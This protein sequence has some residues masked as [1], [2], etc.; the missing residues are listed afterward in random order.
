MSRERPGD[1]A[2][3]APSG[4]LAVPVIVLLVN[5]ANLVGVAT[6]TLLLIGVAGD[7]GSGDGRAAVLWTALGYTV[8][9]L[10]VGTLVGMR[11][12]RVTNAWLMADR[13]PTTAEAAKALRLPVDT[14][15]VA[16][17]IW[18]VAAVLI[19]VVSAAVFPD[20]RI[21]IRTGVATLLGGVVTAGVTYL[22]VARAARAVTA[23]AL[24]AHPPA[25]RLTLGVRPRLLLT[26]GLTSGVPLLGLV[27]LFLDPSNPDG[28]GRAAVVFLSVV[29]LLVG[30]LATLLTARYVGQPRAALKGFSL[31]L[32]PGE[33]VA[34][35]GPSGAGK[36]TVVNLLLRFLD[37]EAGRLTLAGRDLREY[38]LEDARRAFAVA[39]QDS[40]LFSASIRDNVRL[41]CPDAPE[42]EI[43]DA[44]RRARIWDW[45]RDLPDGLDTFVGEQGR[46]LSGGQRQ[47]VV[48]A[49]ALLAG[50][51]VLVLDEP[52]AH[53][54]PRT[55]A[56][57]MRD[58]MAA[59]GGR[60]VLLITHR[61]EGLE[62]VD[63]VLTVRP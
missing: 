24:A 49:R 28:P 53:L 41:A 1:W 21:G 34:L 6:V 57:L 42:T 37:P 23:R 3:W 12:Q 63:R 17:V 9:A 50:A 22:L 51:P 2:S 52:T 62:L 36:T 19:G 32:A 39:G 7:A 10:P 35:V 27:L 47:R 56:E 18:A 46:E 4:R 5:V 30:G 15:I 14:A 44:L 11:R 31:R 48:V 16:G 29:A 26:W 55:A 20:A 58:V 13:P 61:S 8:V 40:H 25:G 43:V 33:R 45:V 38:R 54:D 59:A 60:S